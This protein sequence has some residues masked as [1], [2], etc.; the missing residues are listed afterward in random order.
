VLRRVGKTGWN[1]T[2]S[3]SFIATAR[4]Q[5][6]EP[7]SPTSS[8]RFLVVAPA[9]ICQMID[10]VIGEVEGYWTATT[11]AFGF[12]GVRYKRAVEWWWPPCWGP[13]SKRERIVVAVGG[14]DAVV[15]R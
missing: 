1:S 14:G 13:F 12:N 8:V 2:R 5:R 4:P 9:R 11:A 10:G 7:I 15:A 3:K 6:R